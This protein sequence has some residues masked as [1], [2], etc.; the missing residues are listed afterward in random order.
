MKMMGG[1]GHP[2]LL[3]FLS[4]YSLPHPP[5]GST[6]GVYLAQCI[7]KAGVPPGVFNLVTGRGSEIGDY[8]T[9]HPGVNCISFTGGDTGTWWCMWW[10]VWWCMWWCKCGGKGGQFPSLDRQHVLMLTKKNNKT[11]SQLSTNS[12]TLNQ[13]SQTN[14]P[15]QVSALP[16][17]LA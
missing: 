3:A 6:T 11:H 10:C 16:K 14:N 4:T 8:L 7:A 13:Q 1:L 5:P 2:R 9:T 12:P 17:R 15:N